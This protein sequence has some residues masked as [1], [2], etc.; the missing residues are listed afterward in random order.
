MFYINPRTMDK[1]QWLS[2]HATQVDQ[3]A[4]EMFTD[5]DGP[6]LPCVWQSKAPN[7]SARVMADAADLAQWFVKYG[8]NEA[9]NLR[10]FF[11]VPKEA[12]VALHPELKEALY[13]TE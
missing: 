7:T 13:G 6:T 1:E 4:V 5:W 2:T 3:P 8:D 10:Q 12:L 11:L 9:G